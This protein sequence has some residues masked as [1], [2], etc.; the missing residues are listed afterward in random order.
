MNCDGDEPMP[1]LEEFVVP[2]APRP[3]A[4]VRIVSVGETQT[5]H[6]TNPD[7]TT[8][9]FDMSMEDDDDDEGPST[10]A[11]L[12][13][14]ANGQYESYQEGMSQSVMETQSSDTIR[15]ILTA[16]ANGRRRH[17]NKRK[18]LDKRPHKDESLTEARESHRPLIKRKDGSVVLP[19]GERISNLIKARTT[20][21]GISDEDRQK[22]ANAA[23]QELL[24][25]FGIVGENGARRFPD[26]DSEDDQVKLAQQHGVITWKK[27][28]KL[29]PDGCFRFRDHQHRG[30]A[31][32]TRRVPIGGDN[33]DMQMKSWAGDL[34]NITTT[35]PLIN[36]P[37]ATPMFLAWVV[38]KAWPVIADSFDVISCYI[39][40]LRMLIG[41]MD[42]GKKVINCG[43][44]KLFISKDREQSVGNPSLVGRPL[45]SL[46]K[47]EERLSESQ[48]L[49][50][51]GYPVWFDLG[52]GKNPRVQRNK[53]L[54][55]DD[56]EKAM[57]QSAIENLM[58]M[59]DVVMVQLNAGLT[60]LQGNM[61]EIKKRSL[62]QG[63]VV[64]LEI[65]KQFYDH[66]YAVGEI[67]TYRLL[68]VYELTL[69]WVVQRHV[70]LETR[71]K[72]AKPKRRVRADQ[73]PAP[74]VRYMLGCRRSVF[75]A[76]SCLG[77]PIPPPRPKEG[78]EGQQQQQ[79][80]S[81]VLI[82]PSDPAFPTLQEMQVF[83]VFLHLRTEGKS[84]LISKLSRLNL[85]TKGPDPSAGNKI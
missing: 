32:G 35:L 37:I 36:V 45:W 52:M 12:A 69:L 72:F 67:A 66:L 43:M 2:D 75:Q 47:E 74:F 50:K 78:V 9:V 70:P 60:Q 58:A 83:Y 18:Q 65:M 59:R 44:D 3:V 31:E 39:C 79:Q 26:P 77:C 8:Q 23:R 19:A 55:D 49:R 63:G 42:V 15:E 48:R 24:D 73:L 64:P 54:S 40:A 85:A 80:Q 17:K 71:R 41:G 30:L 46:E 57:V 6:L 21:P 25:K 82:R 20:A 84:D 34:R 27:A 10:V 14:T 5:A 68:T 51:L 16:R 4:Q 81:H 38:D 1:G 13:A 22:Q 56:L 29:T 28:P 53:K 61:D 11:P 7:G 33:F 62:D 76:R